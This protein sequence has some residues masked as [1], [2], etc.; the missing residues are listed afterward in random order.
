ML[1]EHY[2][3]STP[4]TASGQCSV[5]SG[6]PVGAAPSTPLRTGFRP[7]PALVPP[8]DPSRAEARSYPSGR[9]GRIE[10]GRKGMAPTAVWT[11]AQDA[12]LKKIFGT[13]NLADRKEAVRLHM[14]KLK[15]HTKRAAAARAVRLGWAV[16]LYRQRRYWT[17]EQD[18]Y[19]EA[20]AHLSLKKLC[21]LFATRGWHRSVAAIHKRRMWLVGAAADARQDK[22][23]Y[24]VNEAAELLGMNSSAI[25]RF[26]RDGTIT[27]IKESSGMV[28]L[29]GYVY[30]IR[31]KDLREFVI[32]YTAHIRIERVDKY[33]FVDLLCPQHGIK[34]PGH[35]ATVGVEE[36]P[37]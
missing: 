20:N 34:R 29:P 16:P 37:A 33:A 27:A 25:Q 11:E 14:P 26:C 15:P 13:T 10:A 36:V 30:R 31:A 7:R 21:K 3:G 5:A 35:D 17:Q 19:L 8:A 12:L 18:E 9:G 6:Q 1:N 4:L 28:A 2:S 24:T 32:H 22:G 23:I